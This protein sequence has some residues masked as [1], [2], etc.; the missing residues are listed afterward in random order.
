MKNAI[1]L[2]L[3][4]LKV[5][6]VYAQYTIS[7]QPSGS[8][9]YL[10]TITASVQYPFTNLDLVTWIFPDGQYKQKEVLVDN[11]GLVPGTNTV[12]WLPYTIGATGPDDIQAYVAKKGGTGNPP[13]LA[14]T[15]KTYT[16]VP[17]ASTPELFY[18]PT[19]RNWQINRSWEFSPVAET[20]LILSYKNLISSGCPAGPTDFV[21]KLTFD[22]DQIDPVESH[23]FN[24]QVVS[25][26]AIEGSIE[27]KVPDYENDLIHHHVFLKV[28]STTQIGDSIKIKAVTTN[29]SGATDSILL[30][31]VAAAGP[32]DPNKKT[33]DIDTICSNQSAIKLT[34]TVQFHND[35]NAEVD[36][37]VVTDD[38]PAG[39]DQSTF[40]LADVPFRIGMSTPVLNTMLPDTKEITFDQ[41]A[42]PGI[43]Q[44]NPSYGYD[45]T[46]YRYTFTVF[47]LE[48]F[49]NTI[50][51][52]AEVEFY[53]GT[54][55]LGTINTNVATVTFVDPGP[56]VICAT[57]TSEAPEL[58]GHVDMKPNPFYDRI[59]ISFELI[60]KSKLSVEVFDI[61]GALIRSVASG[62]Y[63][64]GAQHFTF[65]GTNIPSGVYLL[66]LRTEKGYLVKRMVKSR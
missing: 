15:T 9:S 55:S 40:T 50:N 65:D 33:V 58:F 12:E 8:A 63:A 6:A 27:V 61:R 37:I 54:V 1:V 39:L 10:C 45:Q 41:M 60:E 13:P 44:T 56:G 16:V 21:F 30:S 59:D 26:P 25:D 48:N 24:N 28:K 46:I 43:G 57:P 64:A 2:L 66:F 4:L 51:N 35:G 29:C 38:L 53:D 20:Y 52:H 32:H 14:K 47:T 34:Y 3:L 19:G 17:T 5:C 22:S 42:L 49:N 18:F 23:A 7:V 31:Y 11:Q 36:K 62:E